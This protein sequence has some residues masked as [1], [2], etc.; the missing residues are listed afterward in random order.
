MAIDE[1]APYTLRNENIRAHAKLS[2]NVLWTAG[3]SLA[4]HGQ[5]YTQKNSSGK[6]HSPPSPFLSSSKTFLSP[7]TEEKDL[8]TA[9]LAFSSPDITRAC[10][11][12]LGIFGSSS[13][14]D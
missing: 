1:I 3:R 5:T 2:S 14:R 12:I 11:R 4:F 7:S 6:V 8:C 9:I 10:G 13:R